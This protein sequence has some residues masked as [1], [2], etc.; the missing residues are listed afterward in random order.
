[1]ELGLCD[2]R[3]DSLVDWNP[4]GDANHASKRDARSRAS[5]LNL[6][7]GHSKNLLPSLVASAKGNS[8]RPAMS[9]EER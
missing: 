7:A 3:H 9:S 6:V 5:A 1:M 4:E 2:V 8:A